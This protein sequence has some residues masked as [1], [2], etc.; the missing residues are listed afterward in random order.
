MN[1]YIDNRIVELTA[2]IEKLRAIGVE[3]PGLAEFIRGGIQDAKNRVRELELL[4]EKV[5]SNSSV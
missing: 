4:R 3:Y 5:F 1:D 2:L